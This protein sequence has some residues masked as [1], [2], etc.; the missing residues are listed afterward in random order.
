MSC[1]LG[2]SLLGGEF[3]GFVVFA[4]ICVSLRTDA[5]SVVGFYMISTFPVRTIEKNSDRGS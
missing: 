4:W 1:V 3:N 2:T 5:T